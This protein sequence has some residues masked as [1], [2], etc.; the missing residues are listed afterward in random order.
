MNTIIKYIVGFSSIL[1]LAITISSGV[2]AHSKNNNSSPNISNLRGIGMMMD[3]SMMNDMNKMHS[4]M[5]K[6]EDIS[7]EEFE[8]LRN[9][10]EEHM[11]WSWMNNFENVERFN[12][13]KKPRN[14]MSEDYSMMN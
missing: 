9:E 1:I 5:W 2:Y 8:W 11:G 13:W 10:Q 12:E 14:N 6:N 3:T 7:Q 4:L